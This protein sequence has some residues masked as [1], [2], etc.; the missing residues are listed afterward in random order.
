MKNLILFAYIF[1]LSPVFAEENNCNPES[2][3]TS[4]MLACADEEFQKY[5]ALL[6]KNYKAAMQAC[7]DEQ[8]CKDS[9]RQM[10]RHWIAYKEAAVEYILNYGENGGG[11]LGQVQAMAWLADETKKQA[12]LLKEHYHAE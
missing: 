9:L 1:L 4:D 2:S 12:E 11:T 8:K 7:G 3:V 10:Q 6:N 5:D